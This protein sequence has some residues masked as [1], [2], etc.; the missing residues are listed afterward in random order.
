MAPSALSKAKQYSL[1]VQIRFAKMWSDANG[2]VA[3]GCAQ[4]MTFD[5]EEQVQD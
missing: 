2:S 4:T 3:E 5:L 1:P